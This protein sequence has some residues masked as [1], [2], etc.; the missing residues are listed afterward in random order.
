MYQ[1]CFFQT[2]LIQLQVS[3]FSIAV[4]KLFFF[5]GWWGSEKGEWKRKGDLLLQRR[6][7]NSSV[8]VRPKKYN[9]LF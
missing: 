3:S 6:I 1:I 4:A 5:F 7:K 8:I 9:S 2:S